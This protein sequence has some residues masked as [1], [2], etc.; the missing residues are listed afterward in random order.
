M[1]MHVHVWKH[2]AVVVIGVIGML[3]NLS[4]KDK[5][6]GASERQ[7]D[8][9]EGA[10]G[11][12]H[13]RGLYQVDTVVLERNHNEHYARAAAVC[14]S[15]GEEASNANHIPSSGVSNIVRSSESSRQNG[16]ASTLAQ[17]D[18]NGHMSG[19]SGQQQQAERGLQEA[20]STGKEVG[21]LLYL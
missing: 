2:C 18:S 15:D 20:G 6:E 16:S 14:S 5:K 1:M 21:S 7:D 17:A 11:K 8:G 19:A 4:S 13:P 9:G 3:Q 12:E 10:E